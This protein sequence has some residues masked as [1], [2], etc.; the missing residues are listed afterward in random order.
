MQHVAALRQKATG[1]MEQMS[2]GRNR[3]PPDDLMVSCKKQ[4]TDLRDEITIVK[5]QFSNY[6]HQV[7]EASEASVTLSKSVGKFYSKAN[8]PGR[9]ESVNTYKKVQEDIAN[10]AVNT[11]HITVENGLISELSEWVQLVNNLNDK[12]GA[13]EST[14]I[15]AH[16][17]Q[18]RLISLQNEYQDKKSKKQGLFGGHK[19]QDLEGLQQR[20]A[21]ASDAQKS[22]SAEYQKSRNNIAQQVK[23]LMEKRYRYFDRIYVQMLECQAEYFQHCATQSKRFQRDIDYYRKQYPKTND[24]TSSNGINGDNSNMSNGD[25]GFPSRKRSNHSD[26]SK[27]NKKD[28]QQTSSNGRKSPRKTVPKAPTQPPPSKQSLASTASTTTTQSS[29]QSSSNPTTS[30][31]SPIMNGAKKSRSSPPQQSMQPQQEESDLLGDFAFS[32]HADNDKTKINN[33]NGLPKIDK[34][35]P[36]LLNMTGGHFQS[37]GNNNNNTDPFANSGNN[38]NTHISNEH[39]DLLN[40]GNPDHNDLLGMYGGG[41][42]NH[43]RGQHS[44]STSAL[45]NPQT[46]QSI[47]HDDDIFGDWQIASSPPTPQHQPQQKPLGKPS[48]HRQ[49]DSLFSGMFGDTQQNQTGQQSAKKKENSSNGHQIVNQKPNPPQSST[50]ATPKNGAKPELS[51]EDKKKMVQMKLSQK[52][53]AAANAAYQQAMDDRK[54]KEDEQERIIREKE[55]YKNKHEQILNNWEFENTVRRNIRTLIGKLPDVLSLGDVKIAWKPIPMTKLLNDAQLKKGY[56]KAVRVVHPDKSQGRGDSIENQVICDYVFQALE[57][58]FN[59][60]FG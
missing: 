30:A 31:S 8:H 3:P 35:Q 58:A 51:D 60:K 53:Q 5:Q 13:A 40:L 19:E 54:K 37:S 15:S 39:D 9:T 43:I 10:R 25:N 11:F 36:S 34:R 41:N 23:Q 42:N 56:Y 22:L 2:G 24:F 4:L 27:S 18:N 55:F 29:S 14:R 59:T 52:G 48:K 33:N 47:T 21:E 6:A 28:N 17:T 57:Q 46:S 12:I 44:Q 16:D 38:N 49:E 7:V 1:F 45:G 20:I 26:D 50:S 32:A